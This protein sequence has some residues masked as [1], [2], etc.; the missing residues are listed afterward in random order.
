[1]L[2]RSIPQ[3]Y[4]H[5]MLVWHGI[6]LS[7]TSSGFTIRFENDSG[8][9]YAVYGQFTYETQTS[10]TTPILVVNGSTETQ[11]G[12][13]RAFG[14]ACNSATVALQ[15]QGRLIIYNY[16]STTRRKAY[17]LS[18]GY[19]REDNTRFNGAN[20]ISGTYLSTSAIDEINIVRTDG[21]GSFSNST[22]SSIRL[23]GI[24]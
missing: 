12:G 7:D 15:G 2:F 9:N 11:V 23:Y 22:N 13:N 14:Y 20:S 10:G 3:T 18:F 19:R 21:S 4:D 24:G 1:M 5:L 6:Q 16:A 17:D 8:S